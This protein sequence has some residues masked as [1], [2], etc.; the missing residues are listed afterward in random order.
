MQSDQTPTGVDMSPGSGWKGKS[1]MIRESDCERFFEIV[2]GGDRVAARL[3]IAQ[4]LDQG[5][6]PEDVMLELYWPTLELVQK[7]HRSDQLS[8]LAHHFATRLIRMLVDQMAAHYRMEP[9]TNRSVL[10]F[11]GNHEPEELAA[12]MAVDMLEMSGFEVRFGGGGIARD[13]ILAHV[14]QNQ[15]DVLLLFASSPEDLPEIRQ[16]IDTIKEIGASEST[17]IAVGGGVF[18]RAPG[19][20]EE[21]GADTWANSPLDLVHTLIEEP[22]RRASAD[23]RTVGKKRRQAA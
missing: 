6:P 18:T 12:Q 4:L 11:C 7:L 2:I 1:V 16:L 9:S 17:Q 3:A 10:A 21:I 20:A 13:E 5:V 14:H 22:K 8:N 15:P 23:Q 19:L